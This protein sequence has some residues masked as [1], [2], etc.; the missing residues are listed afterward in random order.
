MRSSPPSRLP[1][2]LGLIATDWLTLSDQSEQGI[3]D[4]DCITLANLH[5]DAVDYPKSGNPVD[6]KKL[7]RLK[8]KRKP[9]WQAPETIDASG[10]TATA[11]YYVSE[12][13]LGKLFRAIDLPA[14]NVSPDATEARGGRSARRRN[15]RALQSGTNATT[16]SPIYHDIEERVQQFHVSTAVAAQE[17]QK[18]MSDLLSRWSSDLQG[19]CM[20]HT[21]SSS[22]HAVLREEEAF[23]GTITQATSQPRRRQDMMARLRESTQVLT[24]E[25]REELGDEDVEERYL[26]TSWV[27]W[28][29]ALSRGGEFGA[30][31]FGWVALGGIFD[32]IRRIEEREQAIGMGYH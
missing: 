32:A 28:V 22:R 4:P 21:I 29:T 31:S 25:L 8:H 7:P 24:S 5:S 9:D 3:H 27:A 14:E 17:E 6:R 12:H 13:Y 15:R 16:T 1:Q 11:N 10:G 2:I 26:R 30:Q 23:M 18:R 20:S 19:I